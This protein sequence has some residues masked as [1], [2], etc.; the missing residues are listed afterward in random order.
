MFR[1]WYLKLRYLIRKVRSK[2]KKYIYK[3]K[4]I[5]ILK[6]IRKGYLFYLK[7]WYSIKLKLLRYKCVYR[8]ERD[9][10]I[11]L[12]GLSLLVIHYRKEEKEFRER[13][14]KYRDLVKNKGLGF[15]EN[16]YR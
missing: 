12:K 16:F 5:I 3:F 11:V 13:Y 1:N 8:W 15:I 14:L 4:G 7:W 10:L 9:Y 6:E 2:N